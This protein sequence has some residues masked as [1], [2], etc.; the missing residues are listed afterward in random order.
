MA[1]PLRIHLPGGFYHTT[2][3]G[4]HR[5]EI[6]RVDSDRLL[7]NTIVEL[8][9]AKHGARVH[10]YCWMTNHLH[11]LVQ[12]GTDPLANLMRRVASGYARAFQANRDTTGHLFEKRYHAVLVDTDTYLLELIRYIHLNPVRARLT[13]QV[14]LYRWSSHHAYCGV[15]VDQWVSTEF[16][17]RMFA[18]DRSKALAA[19]REFINCDASQVPSPLNQI[20]PDHPHILGSNEFAARVSNGSRQ[21]KS[22]RTLDSLILESCERHH[23]RRD[24]LASG[25]RRAEFAHARA[26]IARQAIALRIATISEIA[27]A[28]GCDPKTI[29][30]ALRN[31]RD[32]EH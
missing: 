21:S 27:R 25:A 31:H 17:L 3:R 28:L 20:H 14:Q 22:T 19:Y 10:A 24:D 15:N 1:R 5:E 2:L 16:G 12:V 30:N 8:A 6:F 7:L 18:N 32:C 9:L 23:L 4:N 29:R 11:M 26:W 13:N